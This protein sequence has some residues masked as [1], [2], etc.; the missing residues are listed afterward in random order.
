MSTTRRFGGTGLG[1]SI[2]ERPV[3]LVGGRL[4][5]ESE[6]G[7]GSSFHFQVRLPPATGGRARCSRSSG[8][9]RFPAAGFWLWTTM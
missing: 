9:Q 8:L 7:Q 1:L 4:W 5:V 6:E 3:K 2:S